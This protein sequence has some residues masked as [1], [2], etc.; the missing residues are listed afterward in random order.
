MNRRLASLASRLA[1]P[2]AAALLVTLAAASAQAN[3][4]G[5]FAII[6]NTMGNHAGRLCVGEGL[7]VSDIGCP[8]YAPSITTAGDVSITGNVSANKFIGDG[9]L[10]T[11][12]GGGLGDRI[13]SG[14]VSVTVNTNG[15]VSLSTG[16]TTWGY[17]H[18]LASYLPQLTSAQVSASNVSGTQV[19]LS[20][21]NIANL[22]GPGGNF[23][24]SGTTSISAS[25]VGTIKF[26]AGGNQRMVIESNGYVGIGRTS[27]GYAVD[28]SISGPPQLMIQG[29]GAGYLG[30]AVALKSNGSAD[31]RGQGVMMIDSLGG[32]QWYAGTPYQGSDA[33][34]IARLATGTVD[35]SIAQI[36]NSKFYINS[37]GNVGIGT[38]APVAKLEIA[39]HLLLQGAA[40]RTISLDNVGVAAPAAASAGMKLQLH[41]LTP[42]TMATTDYALGVESNYLWMNSNSGYKWYSG[43]IE[44]MRLINTGVLTVYGTNTCT[45]A[46]DATPSC[47]SDERLKQNIRP[48]SSALDKILQLNGVT[49]H[50]KKPEIS[51][52]EHIGLIAQNVESV[53]PQAVGAVSDTT[54][55]TA[56]TVAYAEL[57]APMIE[58]MKELK[59]ANDKQTAD[60]KSLRLELEQLKKASRP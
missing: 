38:T 19:E 23:I 33:F 22:G 54:L 20:S 1:T 47:T 14:T 10:L 30:A 15:Y 27:P 46:D 5:N 55:G 9:S 32:Q 48:I 2:L 18:S 43:A 35:T 3:D 49:Y 51:K 11:G 17:L 58:A 53:F 29:G 36:A 13:T 21:S 34:M 52:R 8:T 39:G 57:I 56:K 40:S 45:I 4:W 59:A 25:D 28:V 6:S 60:I 41:G 42:N 44:R 7:R 24:A 50:W 31:S 12:V 26:A 37:S 16:V